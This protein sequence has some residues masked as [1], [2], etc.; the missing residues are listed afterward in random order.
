MTLTFVLFILLRAVGSTHRNV[1]SPQ[2]TYVG[3]IGQAGV[4]DFD[5]RATRQEV[6]FRCCF[7]CSPP[8]IRLCAA[9]YAHVLHHQLD[10]V[11]LALF[12]ATSGATCITPGLL[13][14][15]RYSYAAVQ[16]IFLDCKGGN[17]QYRGARNGKLLLLEFY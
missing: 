10:I 15:Y 11:S 7:S 16:L 3:C 14:F 9:R 5:C 8:C 13:L 6:I 17:E 2:S 4:F 12:Q 1:C